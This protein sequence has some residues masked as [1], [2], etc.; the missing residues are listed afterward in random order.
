MGAHDP[1]PHTSQGQPP[2]VWDASLATI[3]AALLF[4][5]LP[6][7]ISPGASWLP[8]SVVACLLLPLTV[9]QEAQ[10][11]PGGW[12]PQP[13]LLRTL[14]LALL[15][16]LGLAEVVALA[17]LLHQLPTISQGGLLFRS[18][19]LIWAVNVLVFALS[20]WELDGG[21]PNQRG[22]STYKPSAFLFPQQTQE[23]LNADWAPWFLD[24][25]FLAFNTATAFSPTDTMILSRPA[26]ALMMVQSLIAL[27]TIGLVVARGVNI[28]G[29]S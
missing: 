6:A 18:A 24:Y 16:T 21:G 9:A 7:T 3:G 25:L 5:P 4:V 11:R 23:D 8:I 12:E 19:A 17:A 26:K 1:E 28:I 20:Y 29:G 13:R 14:S 27:L 22:H 10:R 2:R 15:A